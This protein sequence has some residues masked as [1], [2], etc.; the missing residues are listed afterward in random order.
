MSDSNGS[1][2]QGEGGEGGMEDV[3]QPPAG[4]AGR[5]PEHLFCCRRCREVLFTDLELV[6]HSSSK[7]AKGNKGFRKGA[8]GGGGSGSREEEEDTDEV[9][10][11]SAGC[12]SYFLD[13][14][15]TPWVAEESRHVAATMGDGVGVLPDTVYCKNSKCGAKLGTQ[16]WTGAQCSCGAWVTPAFRVLCKTVDRLPAHPVPL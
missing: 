1:P 3:P 15:V 13:P 14:D 6:R 7:N 9:E 16:S 5:G 11:R 8:R 10:E 12:T 2:P 4:L